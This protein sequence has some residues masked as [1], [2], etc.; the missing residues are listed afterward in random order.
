ML[1]FKKRLSNGNGRQLDQF[2]NKGQNSP[3][4]PTVNESNFGSFERNN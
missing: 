4:S 3:S 1:E 2:N